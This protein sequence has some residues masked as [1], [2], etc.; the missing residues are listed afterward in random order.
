[1]NTEKFIANGWTADLPDS[2]EDRSTI[3][4]VGET[5]AKGFASNIVV[6]RENVEPQTSLEEYAAL[7][8]AMMRQQLGELQILDERAVEINGAPAFQRLQRFAVD[9]GGGGGQIIQQVQ[10]FFL[11]EFLAEKIVFTV[12][13]TATVE[14][15]DRSIPAFKRFV[16]T[17]RFNRQ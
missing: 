14:S 8:A 10:T 1:M 16:E 4:L 9:G 2:W 5:D 3:T 11:A 15:F 12:T 6:T 7:Q 17:F 13:G